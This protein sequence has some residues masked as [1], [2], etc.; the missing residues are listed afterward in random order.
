MS[1][2]H[3]HGFGLKF[4]ADELKS[5]GGAELAADLGAISADHLVY[6]SDEGIRR[7]AAAGTIAV[8]LPA[9][10]FFLGH[11]EYAPARKLIERGVPV[12]IATD[13]NPGSSCTTSLPATM[14]VAAIYL[15][16][17]AAEILS[18]VTYNAACAIE[19]GDLLGTLEPGKLA[20]F[21]IWDVTDFSQIPYLFAQNPVKA[22]YKRGRQ[23]V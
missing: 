16:M 14:T 23:A 22:V 9:T 21:V 4:H 15:H 11:R 10:T 20:D 5:V 7:M 12:A 2:A 19:M 6:I 3:E 18:S 13:F 8:L 1:A 17:S